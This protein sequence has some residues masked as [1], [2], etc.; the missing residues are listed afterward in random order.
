MQ[1]KWEHPVEIASVTP[2]DPKQWA[3]AW[4][5]RNKAIRSLYVHFGQQRALP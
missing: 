3:I 1:A 4:V 5:D 2:L